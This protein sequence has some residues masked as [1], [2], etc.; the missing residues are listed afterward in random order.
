MEEVSKSDFF[1]L[2]ADF[3][4]IPFTQTQAWV[5]TQSGHNDANLMFVVDKLPHPTIACVAHI[6]RKFG[7]TI[8]YIEAERRKNSHCKPSSISQFYTELK[9]LDVDVI[10]VN[11]P[12]PYFFDYEIGIRQAGFLRPVGLF[13]VSLS[14]HIQLDREIK[15]ND[16]W[17]R[18]IKK[19]EAFD[20]QFEEITEISDAS[21]DDF[22]RLYAEMCSNKNLPQP[23][24]F[25]G[26]K[27]LLSSPN[28]KLFFVQNKDK[29]RIATI[30]IHISRTH[31][32]LLYAA[33]GDKAHACGASFFLYDKLLH[34]LA[35]QK[36]QTFDLEKLAPSTHSTNAVFVYKNGIKGELTLVNGEW[37]WYKR[38]YL[39][40]CMYLVK[41]L[42]WKRIEW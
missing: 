15:Y 6:K 22:F 21:I 14:S 30:I 5:T 2:T 24:S 39:R 8:L 25:A 34:H 12:L 31:A 29:E 37:A 10:E 35:N 11:S 36:I 18:N 41:K 16:N 17:K 3:E 33:S 28:F 42:I 38:S 26:I 23:F 4:C 1:Q 19:A 9:Q 20:L 7:Y 32:G 13:S 40:P 27:N